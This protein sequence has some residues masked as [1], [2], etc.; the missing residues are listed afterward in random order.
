MSQSLHVAVQYFAIS[1]THQWLL[2]AAWMTPCKPC[3]ITGHG[4]LP[5][6]QGLIDI[7]AEVLATHC[8]LFEYDGRGF[9]VTGSA[10]TQYSFNDLLQM[11][12]NASL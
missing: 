12:G 4:I 1:T 2:G 10:P 8:P 5:L 3:R 9:L 6:K 11:K 7:Q